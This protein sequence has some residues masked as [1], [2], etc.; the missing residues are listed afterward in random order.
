MWCSRHAL[1]RMAQRSIKGLDI[2]R[3]I[4]WGW[5]GWQPGGREV[6]HVG[7]R[8]VKRARRAGVDLSRSLNVAVILG[9]DGYLVTAL[10]SSD[11][12]RLAL[13]GLGTGR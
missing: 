1:R 6:F 9:P 4:A 8:E 13:H 2:E 5:H 11:R 3:A 12:H 10:R 7:R